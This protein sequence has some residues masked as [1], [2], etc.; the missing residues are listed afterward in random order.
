MSLQPHVF[1]LAPFV[2]AAIASL[3]AACAQQQNLPDISGTWRNSFGEYVEIISSGNWDPRKKRYT[4]ATFQANF[5]KKDKHGRT[6]FTKGTIQPNGT[7]TGAKLTIPTNPKLV[8]NCGHASTYE[9]EVRN[10]KFVVTTYGQK[11]VGEFEND[12]WD[13]ENCERKEKNWK[14]F[15]ISR[16]SK[17]LPVKARKKPPP[18]WIERI[19][20]RIISPYQRNH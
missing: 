15:S 2:L 10:A 19:T 4:T 1:R 17:H 9:A 20:D 14:S 3:K 8:E 7:I 16:A 5:K 11:I 13:T 6:W 18:T 12:T